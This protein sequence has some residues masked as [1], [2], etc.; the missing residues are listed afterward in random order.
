MKKFSILVLLLILS[1]A[2]L[3][4]CGGGKAPDSGGQNPPG[5]TEAAESAAEDTAADTATA[6]GD[7]VNPMI[8]WMQ[9]G[10]FSFD[11]TQI[12]D[13]SGQRIESKGNMA[14]DGGNVSLNM[15]TSVAGMVINTRTIVKDGKAYIISDETKSIIVMEG[16]SEDATGGIATD[17]SGIVK[18]GE[19]TGEIEGRTLPYE[20]YSGG[21]LTVKYY[22][23]GGQVY[24]YVTETGS[25]KATLLIKNPKN[26][27][28]ANAFDIP[29]G[30][31]QTAL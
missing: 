7:E 16:L 15:E 14:V 13:I 9:E 4:A 10:K 23:D 12:T 29:S 17:Y 5:E 25:I 11:Y 24:G 8:R 27:V 1:L 19:G 30:Y 3:T 28:P 21:G 26:S 2:L 18:V 20:E 6:S 22:L 31:T